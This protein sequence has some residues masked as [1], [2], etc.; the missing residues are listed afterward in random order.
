VLLSQL[1]AATGNVKNSKEL[2]AEFQLLETELKTLTED[3]DIS[4]IKKKQ[5]E[6]RI[7]IKKLK[8]NTSLTASSDKAKLI[9]GVV[10][11]AL[12]G[13]VAMSFGAPVVLGYV[14]FTSSGVAAGSTA[15][16]IQS[17]FYG[18]S[19]TGLFSAAQSVGATGVVS[20]ATT[21]TSAT[22]GAGIGAVAGAKY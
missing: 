2:E 11:G 20:A 9:G 17:A 12:V 7:L 15:A 10:L 18:A 19:T 4:E 16:S 13:G 21:V 3:Q 22:V 1:N 6:I 14:G 8:A 5:E